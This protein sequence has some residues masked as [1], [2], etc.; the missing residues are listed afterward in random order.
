MVMDL[1][2][3]KQENKTARKEKPRTDS[4]TGANTVENTDVL[5]LGFNPNR[6]NKE[7][8]KKIRKNH[9]IWCKRSTWMRT[10]PTPSLE[11]GS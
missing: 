2:P 5:G 6:H 9:Q 3:R 1:D 7:R 11:L 8:P 4:P 10:A